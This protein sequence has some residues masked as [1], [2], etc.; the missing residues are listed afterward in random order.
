MQ[1]FSLGGDER[2]TSR[3][4]IAG[5]NSIMIVGGANTAQWDFDEEALQVSGRSFDAPELPRVP[6]HQPRGECI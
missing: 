3:N 1:C 5:E 2:W 6:H 4:C